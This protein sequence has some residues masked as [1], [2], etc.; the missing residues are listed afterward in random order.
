M[1]L[2]FV[3]KALNGTSLIRGAGFS[4]ARDVRISGR[5]TAA[6]AA[7]GDSVFCE[8]FDVGGNKTN[9]YYPVVSSYP[10]INDK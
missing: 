2:G 1:L 10:Y 7:T 3:A 6:S 5:V 8:G 9:W 4:P